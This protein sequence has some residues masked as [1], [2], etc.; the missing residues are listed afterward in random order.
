MDCA[1]EQR[2]PEL[3]T[4]TRAASAPCSEDKLLRITVPVSVEL[5]VTLE[6]CERG[7]QNDRENT[8]DF[9][10]VIQ[11]NVHRALRKCSHYDGI[12]HLSVSIS[13][14]LA[15]IEKTMLMNY[16]TNGR[17]VICRTYV[18]RILVSKTGKTVTYNVDEAKQVLQ[19]A[20][21]LY[22]W[23]GA[24]MSSDHT[25]EVLAKKLEK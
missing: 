23:R 1:Y 6:E 19:S 24:G 12:V 15:I 22:R 8:F 16:G 21:C 14:G 9:G 5:E 3:S 2:T 17:K 13:H 25:Y 11:P 18:R 4:R 20:K 10:D 7:R